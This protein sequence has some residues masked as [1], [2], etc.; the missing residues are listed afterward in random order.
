MNTGSD[1]AASTVEREY[2][3]GP[4]HFI[5]GQQL[6]LHDDAPLRLGGRA[7]AI[8]A[9]LVQHPG[10]LVSKQE[11]MARVW[12]RTV[13]E[14][15]NLKVNVA[16]LRR[17][18]SDD[19]RESRYIATVSGK[20]YR[21]IA[22]VT[23]RN[24]N[25]APMALPA[26]W[27]Q[28][29][30]LP[31][32]SSRM[33]GRTEAAASLL[34]AMEQ[35]RVVSIVGPGGIGK[36]TLMLQVA[37]S[38]IAQSGAEVCFADLAPLSDPQFLTGAIATALGLSV[39]SGDGLQSLIA[40][41]QERRLLL[42]LDSCEHLIDAVASLV[43]RIG[44]G[45][46]GVQVLCTSREPL[47][48]TGEH[49]HRL[50]ALEFPAAGKT[51]TAAQ[52]LEYPAIRLFAARAAQAL[53]GY[54]L[55]EA[56]VP[57]VAEICRRLEGVALAIELAATRMDAF[58][59]RELAARLDDRFVLLKQGRRSSLER[60]RTLD[61]A[62]DW[63]YDLLPENER[64]LLCTLSAFSGGF[65]LDAATGLCADLPGN[66]I[67]VVDGVANLAHKSLLSADISGPRVFYRL[68]DTTRA[69][70]QEKLE[71]Q[72]QLAALN[73][74]HA[75]FHRTRLEQARK[76]L[77]QRTD[78]DWLDAYGRSLD[79][80]RKALAW[81][82]SA[83][84]DAALGVSLTVAAIPLWM[85]LSLPEECC[86]SVKR[87]LEIGAANAAPDQRAAM[88]LHAAL[89]MAI[90]YA[91]GPVPAM[92]AA[93]RRTL[94]LAEVQED[95]KYQQ[96]ALWGMA[97]Y[98][99]YAGEVTAVAGLAERF[100][101]LALD[102]GDHAALVGMDRLAGTA[103]HYAGSQDAAR[104]QL[105]QVLAQYGPPP[106]A[107][108]MARFQLNQRSAILGTL[109]HVLWLQGYPDQA[110]RTAQAA[111]QEAR[112][113]GHTESLMNAI[114]NTAFPLALQM[115]DHQGAAAL[116]EELSCYLV[117][118][119]L[120][121]WD[122]LRSCLEGAMQVVHGQPAGLAQMHA[123]VRKLQVAGYRLQLT[124]HL[125][126]LASFLGRQGQQDAG[127]AVVAEALA[128]CEAG[129][130][131]WN[132]AELLRIKGELVEGLNAALAEQ[133]YRQALAV[134]AQQ[135]ARAWELRAANS[136]ARLKARQCLASDA[137]PL[138][139]AVHRRYTEGFD[140]ADL[141]TARALLDSGP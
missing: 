79:D 82:F 123:A 118:N 56:D 87:A 45:T 109:S 138:L 6:L 141:R 46:Q 74:R 14:E 12:Q 83:E 136:L 112:D 57:A 101:R 108:L 67:G 121:L 90:L 32:P 125:G 47:R 18:L 68:L 41:L 80:V 124:Q 85:L 92:D 97:V 119:A 100:R 126:V 44:S 8:L 26:G 111:L 2:F 33:I 75:G 66:A 58:G 1:R 76:E 134:A 34:R 10:E 64:A 139:R 127:L 21:F 94:E 133:C 15:G 42:V 131:R 102:C 16:A 27:E 103:L 128:A 30:K 24:R 11:L 50:G 55:G 39:H 122:T 25:A 81:A 3:F 106:P 132:H 37:E 48:V 120:T 13:V 36:T 59:A 17:T 40:N 105:E 60:H 86:Q 113:S 137:L 78:A 71:Q 65:T 140:S 28:R 115:G 135:G 38:W 116:L 104:R 110:W 107:S 117:K 5:P 77:A 52:A 35:S 91:N 96:L 51:P 19:G 95:S 69:Y 73:K 70:A 61:A 89:G 43:C 129:Q 23:A 93:W 9:E 54:H 22:P 20:G 114:T 63:S 62:L 130:A 88:K 99:S 31:L 4:F 98:R 53:D 7:L 84:G 29:A 72:G 49:V